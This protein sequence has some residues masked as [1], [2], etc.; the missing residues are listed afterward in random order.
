MP[1]ALEVKTLD[2]A[3]EWEGLIRKS[4]FTRGQWMD[5]VLFG[6]LKEDWKAPKVLSKTGA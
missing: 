5:G 1:E 2:L 3:L 4:A 6:V